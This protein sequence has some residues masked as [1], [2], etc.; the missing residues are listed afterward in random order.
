MASR[1]GILTD[2]PWKPLGS[3]KYLLLAPWV[4][5][6]SYS[7]LVK[8]KSERDISTFL[9]FPFLLWRM[10]HNQIWITLSRY[11]TAKGNARIVDKGI[12]FDQVDRERDWD[13]QILFNGLLYYLASYTLSGASR[14]P[15]WRTDGV[16]MAILLHAGPLTLVFTKTASVGAMLG[17]VTY[18][19]FMN[20]MGH[21]NFEV[22]PKWLF[23]IFPP[24][25]YLMYTSSFH[26]L[27]HTQFRTN[28]SLFMPLY[29]YIYGTTD[30]ASDKLHESA[31]KQEEEIP[32]VVHL[33][34]LTTPE[35]IYHLRLGFAYLA[36][37]PYT[38]KWYLCLMWPVTAWSMI[39]T[40]VY[41]RTFIVEGNRFDKLKLQ[42]WAIPKYSL[43]YFMQSQKVAINTM[44]EE[45][46]LDA[47]RKGIKV[48]S[49]GLRNQGE[50]LNIYGGL[51]VS[52]HPKLKVRVVDG[53]SLVVAVVLNSIPKGTT[54]VLLR[55]KLTK[56]AYALAY[57]L[58]QQGVQ[59][60]ALYEDDYV[61]LKKSFNSSETNL[62]FTKSSTQTTWL[63]GDGLTEEEQLKAP[64]GTLFI[65]Y[66]QFPPRKYRK[67]CFY[68]CTP[69][70]LAPCSVENIH[71]CED[72]LP[73]RIMSAW[74]IAGIVHSLEGW[75]EHECG[76]TMHNIDNVWHSTLQHGFQPL[77]VPINE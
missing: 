35:S 75:T 21:C 20:N 43:Q 69:A 11:R 15:L 31:L 61:R 67:D 22:V 27:H 65:P 12:E 14:I 7:V 55:G 66:T 37:K 53:S 28:Y 6:S 51:Y 72:W 36:S 52:R 4:V 49:L 16:V 74:R 40:W 26:S 71:S 30:K 44:I 23:D 46:I 57:T 59:V 62:A 41:G 58:C 1:P 29:D 50:D 47:D 64:K 73:R 45:A 60:A 13:D 68:H 19:D 34:H 63:V 18:I 2:W 10:L 5:H 39:L 48:L 38:S 25:K 32:N 8:D 54:Q 70:M 33:T 77:P 24:L 17:Y 42:T 9:I 76:H 56:I 3:F